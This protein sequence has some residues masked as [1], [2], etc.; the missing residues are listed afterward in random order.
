MMMYN[1]L[2]VL[3]SFGSTGLANQGLVVS[4][5]LINLRFRLVFSVFLTSIEITP[6][7]SLPRLFDHATRSDNQCTFLMLSL[8]Y[9]LFSFAKF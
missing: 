9:K 3:E 4:T 7:G 1:H 5:D 2:P 8:S 6:I